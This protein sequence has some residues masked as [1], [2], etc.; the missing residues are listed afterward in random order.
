MQPKEMGVLPLGEDWLYEYFWNGERV[1]AWKDERGVRLLARDG[2]NLANRFPRVAAA[3]ARLRAAQV[4]ID[5]EV[6]VL[7]T[8]A[9][10]AVALLACASDDISQAQVAFLAYDVLE[11]GG[12][13]M[14]SMPLLGRRVVLASLVQGTPIILSPVI[15]A[16]PTA[17]L[18][19][20][21]RLGLR[22]VVAKRAG[23]SYRPNAIA[24]PWVRVMHGST[25]PAG[26]RT[27]ARYGALA[28]NPLLNSARAPI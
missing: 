19:E 13:D 4:V 22:G 20:A 5:G 28:G 9:P 27:R 8:L 14:R 7:D 23:S 12:K 3:V 15:Q 17:A 1:R 25:V 24:A 2:R 21:A 18:A 6:L 11:H 26:G 16:S 10:G